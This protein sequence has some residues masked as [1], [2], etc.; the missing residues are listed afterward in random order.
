MRIQLTYYSRCIWVIWLLRWPILSLFF[1]TLLSPSLFSLFTRYRRSVPAGWSTLCPSEQHRRTGGQWGRIIS[2]S[3][4][5]SS[6]M[7]SLLPLTLSFSLFRLYPKPFAEEMQDPCAAS[8]GA[9]GKHFG[10][11]RRRPQH[12]GWWCGHPVISA[13]QSH[14]GAFPGC[15]RTCDDQ[16]GAVSSCVRWSL[17][18]GVQVSART[19]CLISFIYTCHVK[20]LISGWKA[21][22]KASGFTSGR[23]TT[24]T[25]WGTLLWCVGQLCP[26]TL[27]LWKIGALKLPWSGLWC[28]ISLHVVVPFNVS[29][30]HLYKHLI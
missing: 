1:R 5:S 27:I 29:P 19:E 7:W 9:R 15:C 4:Y 6:F 30:N 2:L 17:L 13:G 3:L 28:S 10:H 14:T 16:T 11:S 25:W 20:C 8:G 23:W 24:R 22:V 12:E 18:S 21:D 26:P